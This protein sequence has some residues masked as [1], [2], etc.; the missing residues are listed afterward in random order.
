MAA[1]TGEGGED[2]EVR[3]AHLE[4]HARQ[5]TPQIGILEGSF[6]PLAWRGS[7]AEQAARSRGVIEEV[8]VTARKRE[9]RLIDTPVS[10]SALGREALERYNTRDLA[11]LTTRIPGVEIS[12]AAGVETKCIQ[13]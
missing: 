5:N 7:A 13:K 12:H 4:T 8:V 1:A 11:Q 2:P 3:F 6:T 10:V 9:E